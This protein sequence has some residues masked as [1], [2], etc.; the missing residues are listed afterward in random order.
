MYAAKSW[1][2]AVLAAGGWP[3]TSSALRHTDRHR[4]VVGV[5]A[6]GAR[7]VVREGFFV[8]ALDEQRSGQARAALH[9]RRAVVFD[10]GRAQITSVL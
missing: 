5:R 6:G 4:A 3:T 1:T 7:A 2:S 8:A 10:L 9:R